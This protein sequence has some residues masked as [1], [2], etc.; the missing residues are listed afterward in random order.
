MSVTL[1]EKLCTELWIFMKFSKAH[2]SAKITKCDIIIVLATDG[3]FCAERFYYRT[4]VRFCFSAVCNF[5]FFLFVCAS[6]ISRTAERI[7]AKFT[8]KTCLVPR[9][10]EFKCQSQRSKIKVTRNKN[11]FST[12]VTLGSVRM[13]SAR[14]KQRAAAADGTI[15]S[16]PGAA[17][18][19]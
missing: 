5:L 8:G 4:Q 14:C 18:G 15:P 9:S 1:P 2:E 3:I 10:E 17:G 7:C 19:G 16:L 11:A 6:N 12:P 13:V